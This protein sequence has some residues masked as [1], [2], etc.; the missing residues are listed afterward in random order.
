[1]GHKLLICGSNGAGK[2]TLGR[3]LSAATGWKFM[4]AEDYY[5]PGRYPQGRYEA[6]RSKSEVQR[7]LLGDME[8]YSDLIVASV[9]GDYGNAVISRFT[10]AI[11]LR[12]PKELSSARVRARALAQF[13]S[14]ILPGG[15]LF[16]QENTF[17]EMVD[18]RP[19]SEVADWLGTTALPFIELDGAR[20]IAENLSIVLRHIAKH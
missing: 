19:E 3:A 8:K 7:A 14:R 13:G 4:D 11:Y 2:S 15:D 20:P 10:C 18:R 12:I 6:P 9:K 5:F 16:C 1:M 17:F